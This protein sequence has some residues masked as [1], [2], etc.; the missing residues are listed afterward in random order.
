LSFQSFAHHGVRNRPDLPCG[1]V[2]DKDLDFRLALFYGP[3]TNVTTGF[4]FMVAIL[5]V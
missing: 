3:P 1:N 2:P 4:R 5:D